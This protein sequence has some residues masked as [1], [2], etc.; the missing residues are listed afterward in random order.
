M[1]LNQLRYIA[2]R[3][4]YRCKATQFDGDGIAKRLGA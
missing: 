2:A 3:A 1:R 4:R